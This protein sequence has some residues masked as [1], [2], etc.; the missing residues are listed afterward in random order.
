MMPSPKVQWFRITKESSLNLFLQ[1]AMNRI[2]DDIQNVKS[3]FSSNMI[4]HHLDEK[5]K[6]QTNQFHVLRSNMAFDTKGKFVIN[7]KMST[8]AKLEY[9]KCCHKI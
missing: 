5:K 6:M 4:L 8:P 2:Y 1:V 7:L 3:E 9:Q